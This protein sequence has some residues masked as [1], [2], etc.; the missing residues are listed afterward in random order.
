MLVIYID[1][2]SDNINI[3]ERMYKIYNDQIPLLNSNPIP[4][5]FNGKLYG[6]GL[7]NH[8]KF[9][10]MQAGAGYI[11]QPA[12]SNYSQNDAS[13]KIKNNNPEYTY[14]DYSDWVELTGRQIAAS[15][16]G[17]QVSNGTILPVDEDGN[18]IKSKS[19]KLKKLIA[20]KK[21]S[22]GGCDKCH[23][24]FNIDPATHFDNTA[25]KLGSGKANSAHVKNLHKILNNIARKSG[26]SMKVCADIFHEA[27][28]NVHDDDYSHYNQM[29]KE[30]IAKGFIPKNL[31]YEYY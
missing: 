7:S 8:E 16:N 22:M 20:A 10:P 6:N 5:N 19:D 4:I 30:R 14:L 9:I 21:T 25:F 15:N 29:I 23:L 1:M 31:R 13:L 12:P 2:E 18:I 11:D 24:N 3:R 17:N 27:Y 28:K 26:G